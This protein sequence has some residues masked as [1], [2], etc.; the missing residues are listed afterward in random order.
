MVKSGFVL[1]ASTMW[2]ALCLPATTGAGEPRDKHMPAPRQLVGFTEAVF[3]GDAGVAALM[4]ACERE[5]PRSRMAA[6]EEILKAQILPDNILHQPA[7]VRAWVKPDYSLAW[8]IAGKDPRVSGVGDATPYHLTCDGWTTSGGDTR[9][10]VVSPIGNL[11]ALPCRE[12][13]PV[14][15]SG[16]VD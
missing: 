3:R 2:V 13:H 10:L 6:S 4:A 16:A 5:F 8:A 12:S 14:A 1:V 9:G 15:C 7:R 11:G